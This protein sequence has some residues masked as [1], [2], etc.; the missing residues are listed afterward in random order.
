MK[1]FKK[2]QKY[3][4]LSICDRNARW[5]FQVINRTAKMVT[6]K[7]LVS[8]EIIKKKINILDGHEFCYPIGRYSMAPVLKAEREMLEMMKLVVEFSESEL[9]HSGEELDMFGVDSRLERI[10]K[11]TVKK[12]VNSD[13]YGA[14]DKLYIDLKQGNK[15]LTHSKLCLG[16]SFYLNFK[17]ETFLKEFVENPQFISSEGNH[18][19]NVNA[20]NSL[21]RK[22][23][24][25]I[26]FM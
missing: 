22:F 2:G 21:Y 6:L 5:D 19:E 26:I 4:M 18:Q 20:V 7:N 15:V 16:S 23:G 12:Y 25:A 10:N 9:L 11:A 17:I 24:N 14:Y 3:Y 8:N 13:Y 1:K